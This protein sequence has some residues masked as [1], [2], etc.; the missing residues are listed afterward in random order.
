MVD[1]SVTDGAPL[2]MR[3]V[4]DAGEVD[5]Y[6][7]HISKIADDLG[8]KLADS[9]VRI[10]EADQRLG[11][12]ELAEG[13]IGRAFLAAQRAADE[14]ICDAE[15]DGA[16]ILSDARGRAEAVVDAARDHAHVV[17]ENSQSEAAAIRAGAEAERQRIIGNARA[18]A[19]TILTDTRGQ[20]QK[21]IDEARRA[22]ESVLRPTPTVTEQ[23]P[24]E[25]LPLLHLSSQEPAAS[26]PAREPD[27]PALA[28]AD[29]D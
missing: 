28:G 21:I 3:R 16:A 27:A 20:A 22:I 10:E 11:E 25:V 9:A 14:V 29:G 4:Y 8:R 19:E 6:V 18:L 23:D 1:F 24:F 12:L 26:V 2:P 13:M 15:R 7:A 5:R 17:V